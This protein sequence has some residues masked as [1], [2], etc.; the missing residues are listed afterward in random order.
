MEGVDWLEG[1]V[2][3]DCDGAVA[4]GEEEVGWWGG[5]VESYLIGLE[6]LLVKGTGF[7]GRRHGDWYENIILRQ[8]SQPESPCG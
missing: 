5:V 4:A 1:G 3:G 6:R 2:E 7:G 8:E